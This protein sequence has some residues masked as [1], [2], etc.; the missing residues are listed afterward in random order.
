MIRRVH[1]TALLPPLAVLLC[2]CKGTGVEAGQ[3]PQG[4]AAP[5]VAVQTTH[6]VRRDVPRLIS[7]P[8]DIAPLQEATLFSKQ[9]GYLDSIYVDK[10]DR[11]RAGQVLAVIRAPELAADVRQAEDAY[12]SAAQ[13]AQANAAS[14][15]MSAEEERRARAAAEK[16]R[17]DYAQGPAEV[18]AARAQALH[19]EGA[20]KRAQALKAQAEAAL[21]ESRAQVT[22]A[23]AGV[24]AAQAD[25]KLAEVTADR[26][27]GVY[28]KDSKLIA[29]QQVDEAES[30][31][32]AARGKTQAARS[33]A[34]AARKRV[35][36]AQAQVSAADRQ[37]EEEQ[38]SAAATRQEVAVA[39]AK[40]A[41][42]RKQVEMASRDV[43][44]SGRQREVVAAQTEQARLQ[45]E[46]QRSA[47]G[48]STVLA[49]YARLQAP[50]SG[51]VTRRFVDRGA[52]IQTAA[53]TQSAEPVVT[54]A[55]LDTVRVY[56][57]VPE[58]EA[59][60][61]VPGTPVTLT[62]LSQPDSP[63]RASI[64]RTSSSLDPKTRTLLAEVDLPNADHR[65]LPGGYVVAKVALENHPGVIAV[66]SPAVGVEKSGKS[67]FTVEGG[68]VKRVPVTTGFDD[69][70]WTEITSGLHGNEEVIV[71][72][73]DAVSPGAAVTT[74]AWKPKQKVMG[75][76]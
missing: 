57:H 14:G 4:Q 33:E 38:A 62:A 60:R 43:A 66:P 6:L 63:I 51:T 71:T 58:S 39:R 11:V 56:I 75:D 67:V 20:V 34:E 41:S 49:S 72:G 3:T 1:L 40:M 61:A 47:A 15:R 48:R 30:R 12:R 32:E 17:L 8:G 53:G 68:K 27:R 23:E 65:L 74:S 36:A 9:A 37:I 10:G 25:Q 55:D 42:L 29:R 26:Y 24:Q 54:V 44:V 59:D 19:A 76:R 18:A 16:A 5:P 21:E 70:K 46:A 7:L 69:G 22:Q 28:Q 73:R 50:F 31:A 52:F 2:G 64:T 13:A 45:A 35:V